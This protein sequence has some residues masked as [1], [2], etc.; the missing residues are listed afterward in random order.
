M[1]ILGCSRCANFEYIVAVLTSALIHVD[2]QAPLGRAAGDSEN[3][4]FRLPRR[5]EK[6]LWFVSMT[7][8]PS[9]WNVFLHRLFA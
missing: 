8:L 1:A 7:A 6:N 4:A 9:T 5:L 3:L 2:P